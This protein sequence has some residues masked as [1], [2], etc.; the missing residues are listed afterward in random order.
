[1][2]DEDT[3]PLLSIGAR[4]PFVCAERKL[5]ENIKWRE[6]KAGQKRKKLEKAFGIP[7]NQLF[8]P[9]TGD[10][11]I[12]SPLFVG[13]TRPCAPIVNPSWTPTG[14][15]YTTGGPPTAAYNEP[16][17]GN[18]PNCFFIAALS[19]VAF[20]AATIPKTS[21]L[22]A[23]PNTPPDSTTYSYTFYNL[24]NGAPKADLPAVTVS[25]KLPFD[26][27]NRYP[28]SKSITTGEIW[29][30]M[31]EK[32]F[33]CWKNRALGDK[34]DYS[35]ICTGDPV[36]AL[37]NLTGWNYTAA[38]KC[39]TKNFKDGTEIYNKIYS[40][41][42]FTAGYR[43]TAKPMVAYTYDPRIESPPPGITY[44]DAT[45]VANHAYSVLGVHKIPTDN[46][47]IVMRNPWGQKGA[48]PGSGYG[49]PDPSSLP[50]DALASG[51]WYQIPNL[52]DPNDAIFALRASVFKDY[53][54]GFG[55]VTL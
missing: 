22:Q 15:V 10:P 29:V 35:L 51:P 36:L 16:I 52:A 20:A 7:Y 55:W 46:Y 11:S 6:M 13:D 43:T 39:L 17:Q 44:T 12:E 8:E 25:N 32:A 38:T 23:Q 47:Y 37:L 18:L 40:L 2:T 50:A 31:Y 49:D 21:L 19:S 45:I 53:F 30:A 1:M 9:T 41:C 33:A 26:S 34:P 28:Y 14:S 3:E 27:Y 24:V 48:M 54:K 4:N 42:K 5:N